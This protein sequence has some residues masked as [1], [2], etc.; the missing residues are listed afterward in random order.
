MLIL[1]L[2]S[3]ITNFLPVFRL[4]DLLY[5]EQ[6]PL[7]LP[8]YNKS[9]MVRHMAPICI[10]IHLMKKARVEN[11]NITRPLPIALK[12]HHECVWK[13]YHDNFY[14]NYICFLQLLAASCCAKQHDE[15]H[16]RKWLPNHTHLQCLLHK[17][18]VLC[19]PHEYIVGCYE[20]QCEVS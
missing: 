2:F 4:F 20:W 6:E 16:T 19:T 18:G 9:S 12:N 15:R 5:P 1:R 10:W 14:I 11:M 13:Y 3:Q 8:D 7:P 17:S